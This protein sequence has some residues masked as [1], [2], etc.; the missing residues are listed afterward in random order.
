MNAGVSNMAWQRLQFGPLDVFEKGTNKPLH[1]GYTLQVRYMV[2]IKD[3]VTMTSI[4]LDSA[5]QNFSVSAL[6]VD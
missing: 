1:N 3:G 2:S 6:A 4:V 5:F